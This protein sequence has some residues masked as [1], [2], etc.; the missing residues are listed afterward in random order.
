MSKTIIIAEAGVNH[1]GD[2]NIAKEMIE[3]A[4]SCG[5]DFIK[6]QAFN[7]S[8]LATANAPQ[9][10]YQKRNSGRNESQLEMLKKL[11]LGKDASELLFAHCKKIKI[12]FLSSPFDI[13]SIKIL[14]GLNV[15]TFKIPSG[16]ITNYPYLNCIGR[17]NKKIILSTG[18]AN[19]GEIEKALSVLLESGT[20]RKNI[21]LLHCT[22]EYPASIN[23]VNLRAMLTLKEAFKLPI[24][25]SDHTE[26]IEIALAAVAM[27]AQVIEKHFTLNK[28]YK[29]PD[30]KASLE[31]QELKCLVK[32]IRK[33]ENAMGNGVKLIALAES[34]NKIVARKSI[35]AGKN[36]KKG[37]RFTINNLTTKR[38]GNGLNPMLWTFILGKKAIRNFNKDEMIEI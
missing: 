5:A 27:G 1:N 20:L 24:G 25:Y 7:P 9:A 15:K 28:Q 18:M 26:G 30:H 34:Q 14:A 17:F 29:G 37:D 10:A 35:V 6:F 22:T 23:D 4:K 2:M 3:V 13:E 32:A 19:L 33:I 16:E 21:T 36:I 31:P 12:G 11:S 8:L 38:P